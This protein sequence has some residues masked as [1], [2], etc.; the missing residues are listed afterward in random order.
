MLKDKNLK[1]ERADITTEETNFLKLA[2]NIP[3]VIYLAKNDIR[4]SIKYLNK[5]VEKLTGYSRDVFLKGRLYPTD[6]MHP[7]DLERIMEELNQAVTE[8]RTYNIRYRVRNKKGKYFWV[9]DIGVCLFDADGKLEYI[10]GFWYDISDR[11]LTEQALKTSEEKYRYL[12]EN[13][14]VAVTRL[15]LSNKKYETV[16][17]EFTRQSG[18]TLDEFNSLSDQE[19]IEM[20]YTEDRYMI[21]KF[22][23]EWQEE[24]YKGLKQIEYRIIN[25]DKKIVWLRTILYSEFSENGEVE[26]LNQI[27]IDIT[28][29]K[30]TEQST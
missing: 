14:P 22:F 24:G 11:V 27:C 4:F 5:Y 19:L 29:R 2:D 20:I 3:G 10:Q 21:F 18:Y 17:K 7:D 9:A 25:K 13:E 12:V 8:K 6:I 1:K 23:K 16:N 28:E 15:R 30:N 26:F